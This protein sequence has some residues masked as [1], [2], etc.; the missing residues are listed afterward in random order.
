MRLVTFRHRAGAGQEESIGALSAHGVL[1]L[2]SI[3]GS[4]IELLRT[5]GGGFDAARR[6]VERGGS[7]LTLDDVELLAPL[8]RPNSIRDFMLIEEHVKNSFGEVPEAWYEIPV[9]WKGNPDTVI[10][11]D[12]TVAWP[13]YTAKL[14]FELEVGA[15]IGRRV[16]K[17]TVEEAAEAIAGYTVFNDWSARDIQ[18]RE[19]EVSLGPG[20][21][22]DFASSL[23]PCLV[24]PDEIDLGT[25]RMAARVNGETW[26]EGGLGSMLYTF[27]Q[28]IAHLSQ[29][30]PL[31]PGDLLGSG[32]VGR[33]CGLE[34][35]RWIE[36][37]DVVELE[38]QG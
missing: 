5:E 18:F 22:K 8:P 1:D 31:L 30:Q 13:H 19:M 38:V 35:D 36:P 21:G 17:A 29:E 33:G 4:M 14:D 12:A 27:P 9:Y 2:G 26:A 11:P 24:T 23:G 16:W 15:V 28:V 7:V 32:T 34:I 3:A 6:A 20:L 25:A 37:G 10:G